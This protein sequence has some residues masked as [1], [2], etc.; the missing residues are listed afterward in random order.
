MRRSLDRERGAVAPRARSDYPERVVTDDR[1][2]GAGAVA[3]TTLAIAAVLV[4][5]ASSAFAKVPPSIRS[6][7]DHPATIVGS[8]RAD[9]LTGT[10]GRDVIVAGRGNDAI[11]SGA[12]ADLICAGKGNDRIRSGDD[13]DVIRAG[14]GDDEADTGT[15]DDTIEGQGGRDAADGREGTD[16]CLVERHSNCEADLVA[17]AFGPFTVTGGDGTAFNGE[18]YILNRGPTEAMS[19]AVT[20]T[21]PPEA[22]FVAAG[23]D[24]RCSQT[25]A[26]PDQVYCYAGEV[27]LE[28][29]DRAIFPIAFRVP[30]CPPAPGKQIT[31]QAEPDDYATNDPDPSPFSA[32]ISDKPAASCPQS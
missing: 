20:A 24:S 11:D 1:G 18:L 22:E 5:A 10:P 6:C 9:A 4:A 14:S 19:A 17:S 2:A 15:G 7:K 30:D 26:D 8:P 12:G 31:F 25:A 21:F 3:L 32:S 23:S 29:E 16:A 28:Y 27:G 13:D